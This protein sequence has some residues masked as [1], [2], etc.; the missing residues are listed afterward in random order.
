MENYEIM[1]KNICFD[2]RK[3]PYVHEQ[4]LFPLLP[5]LLFYF[6]FG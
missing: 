5:L 1:K 3:F 2:T 4:S 6:I